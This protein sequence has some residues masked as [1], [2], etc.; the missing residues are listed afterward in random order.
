MIAKHENEQRDVVDIAID[1]LKQQKL[2]EFTDPPIEWPSP[3]VASSTS[4]ST[5]EPGQRK[6]AGRS[7]H[8]YV[9]KLAVAA[10]MLAIVGAVASSWIGSANRA[11]AQMQ[12]ALSSAKTV[13]FKLDT[14]SDDELLQQSR[15]SYREP[16]FVR[17]DQGLELH[18][19]NGDSLELMTVDHGDKSTRVEPIYN[20]DALRRIVF[21]VYD[22]LIEMQPVAGTGTR[23]TVVDGRPFLEIRAAFDG[24]VATVLI[25]RETNL[26]WRIDV[27]RGV[28]A[29]ERRREI[30][31]SFEYDRELQESLFAVEVPSGYEVERIARVEPDASTSG[32]V[33]SSDQGMGPIQ[34]GMSLSEVVN[35][36]GQPE[37]LDSRPAMEPELDSSGRPVIVPGKGFNLIPA[38]PA[39]ELATAHYASTGFRIVVSSKE[40]VVSITCFGDRVYGPS[41]R[42]F[43]G[44][45][46]EGIKIGMLKEQVLQLLPNAKDLGNVLSHQGMNVE[47]K[48]GRCVQFS[49]SFAYKKAVSANEQ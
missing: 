34:F 6:V 16:Y 32:F 21:G 48:E 33:L 28:I 22:M 25:D 7:L 10:S 43:L 8:R 3:N 23:H 17:V 45:T 41:S 5:A 35:L 18:V 14:F 44:K 26:P 37:S 46:S 27:D 29:G 20:L 40:G 30:L 49:A 24:D 38:E 12:A 13:V 31:S 15:F 11:L 4:D 2:P 19:L 36:L 39:Y 47:F 9:A 1:L 42:P